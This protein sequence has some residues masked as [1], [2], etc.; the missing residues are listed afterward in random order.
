[1]PTNQRGRNL[2]RQSLPPEVPGDRVSEFTVLGILTEPGATDQPTVV[3]LAPGVS[4][5]EVDRLTESY[6]LRVPVEVKA[7]WEW[8]NGIVRTTH[9]NDFSIGPGG[10]EFLRVSS[11]A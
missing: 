10:Y 6:G 3:A 2:R 1:V 11:L 9:G 5:D 4:P 8:H 7:L